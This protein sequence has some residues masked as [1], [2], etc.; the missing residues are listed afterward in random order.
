M[1]S[2]LTVKQLEARWE[3][4]LR[5]TRSAVTDH[6][7]TYRELKAQA[8]A[9]IDAPVDIQDYLPTVE[10]LT[11]RLKTLDP[12][13]RGSIFALFTERITP[14]TIWHVNM[15]RMECTD[16]LHHLE[17]FDKWRRDQHHLRMV[18]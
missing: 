9:I 1:D 4:A 6:P 18:K 3:K 15:L 7:R 10:K 12:R 16:L 8:A 5:A 17:A 13:G 14:T 2:R 11:H